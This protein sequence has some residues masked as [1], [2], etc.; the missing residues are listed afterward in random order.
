MK[1]KQN[2]IILIILNNKYYK[3]KDKIVKIQNHLL[4]MKVFLIIIIK[5]INKIIQINKN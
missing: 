1:I 3:Y 2:K 5:L 4:L